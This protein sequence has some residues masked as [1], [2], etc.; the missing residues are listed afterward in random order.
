MDVFNAV[1]PKTFKA[2]YVSNRDTL[3]MTQTLFVYINYIKIVRTLKVTM[4]TFN[5]SEN[6]KT[7]EAKLSIVSREF[8]MNDSICH[9]LCLM[10]LTPSNV[11]L[12]PICKYDNGS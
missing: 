2:R 8:A 11:V 10:S 9:I 1:G 7:I 5:T 6:E 3:L 12:Y 4:W